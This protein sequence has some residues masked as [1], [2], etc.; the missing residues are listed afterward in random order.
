MDYFDALLNSNEK[1]T[2]RDRYNLVE[3][4]I[5]CLWIN[6][7]KNPSI[8][9]DAKDFE[10]LLQSLE[11]RDHFI[12]SFNVFLLGYYILN[13]LH[14]E[15]NLNFPSNDFNLTWM[16]ASTFHDVAYS[17]ETIDS[18]LNMFL[19]KF[20]GIGQKFRLKIT[21]NLPLVYMEYLR[22]ISQFNITPQDRKFSANI[23]IKH[24]EIFNEL[25]TKLIEKNHGVLG[26][27]MLAHLMAIRERF[28]SGEDWDFLMNHMPACHAIAI[29]TLKS[30][31]IHLS[32]HPFAFTL[33]LCD[34]LQDWGRPCKNEGDVLYLENLEIINGSPKVLRI[35]IE[36]SEEKKK[37]LTQKLSNLYSSN[38]LLIE[39]IDS[40]KSPV[41]QIKQVDLKNFR[42]KILTTS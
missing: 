38:S 34:E 29:H 30:I 19:E 16:L 4:K 13:R 2:I 17:L 39:V 37:K 28:A 15:C 25:S 1:N 11:Y 35:T 21:E 24:W 14:R 8:F 10:P 18:W 40:K 32:R 33:S 41:C 6:S 7:N 26:G 23:E 3:L 31:P 20:L 36:A 5:A 42:Q 22:K 9:K 12:H 27:L